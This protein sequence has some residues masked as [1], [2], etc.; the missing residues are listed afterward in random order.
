MKRFLIAAGLVGVLAV[1]GLVS[2][3]SAQDAP[4][5][6]PPAPGQG[7]GRWGGQGMM[8]GFAQTGPMHEYMQTALAKALGLTVEELEER[9]ASGETFLQIAE[10]QG[11]TVEEARQM[12]LDARSSALDAMVKDGVITQAQADWMKSRTSRMFGGGTW[13]GRGGC[14][15]GG[16]YQGGA[17][18]GRWG[19][20]SSN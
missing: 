14:M 18:R 9:Y 6:T 8:G 16:Y 7:Y 19:T 11:Y 17:S 4:P 12:M 15:G 20:G 1:F 10:A 3:V 5:Q 13:P 2:A